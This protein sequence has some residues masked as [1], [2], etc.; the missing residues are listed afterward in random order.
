MGLIFLFV[1]NETCTITAPPNGTLTVVFAEKL[2]LSNYSVTLEI[3]IFSVHQMTVKH[4][5]TT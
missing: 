3:P 5:D 2:L 1:K 4:T